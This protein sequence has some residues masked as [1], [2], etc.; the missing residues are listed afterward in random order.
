MEFI[1][2]VTILR[3]GKVIRLG[4]IILSRLVLGNLF[5]HI[6]GFSKLDKSLKVVTK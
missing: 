1:L 2:F 6:P 3:V 4:C 5:W